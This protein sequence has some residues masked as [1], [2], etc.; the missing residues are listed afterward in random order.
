MGEGFNGFS[1]ASGD[2]SIKAKLES[3]FASTKTRLI[4]LVRG[5]IDFDTN[6]FWTSCGIHLVSQI[7]NFG[8]FVI[9]IVGDCHLISAD[10]I[11]VCWVAEDFSAIHNLDNDCLL[12][13]DDI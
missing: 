9:M 12:I 1:L 2:F 13:F 7:K 8:P 3:N 11:F 6:L 10:L 5:H 4:H